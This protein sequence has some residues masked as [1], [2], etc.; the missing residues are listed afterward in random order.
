MNDFYNEVMKICISFVTADIMGSLFPNEKALKWCINI[1]TVYVFLGVIFNFGNVYNSFDFNLNSS[2][3][4][5]L[6]SETEVNDLYLSET[7]KILS[8]RINTALKSVYIECDKIE[9][10]LKIN[11][12]NDVYL[13]SLIINLKYKSD[14]ERAKIVIKELF[15]YSEHFKTEIV[16]DG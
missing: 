9:P 5:E 16:A 6:I 14:I 3:N 15:K 13:D 12:K 11:E 4:S 1:I 7:E 10:L 8:E 2:I